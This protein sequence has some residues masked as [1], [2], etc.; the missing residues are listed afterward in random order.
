MYET[1]PNSPAA[2]QEG[3]WC[4]KCGAAAFWNRRSIR[5]RQGEGYHSL[6]FRLTPVRQSL[7]WHRYHRLPGVYQEVILHQQASRESSEAGL[8]TL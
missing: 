6:P 8:S 1:R 4:T 2:H 3:L 5:C 7:H